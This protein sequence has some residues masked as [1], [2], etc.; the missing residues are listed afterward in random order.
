MPDKDFSQLSDEALGAEAMLEL[1][2]KA[3]KA[4]ELSALFEQSLKR[5]SQVNWLGLAVLLGPLMVL[6]VLLRFT[7]DPFAYVAF[8]LAWAWLV[9]WIIKSSKFAQQEVGE[10]LDEMNR[11]ST[12]KGGA[13]ETMENREFS[14][15]WAKKDAEWQAFKAANP[16]GAKALLDKYQRK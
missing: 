3:E 6:G 10:R 9:G 8:G 1:A 5:R 16:E 4:R 15:R 2:A 14:K 11:A 12:I 7:V 13:T